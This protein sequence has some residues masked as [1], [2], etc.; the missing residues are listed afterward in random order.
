MKHPHYDV[1][2]AWAADISKAVQFRDADHQPWIDA[3]GIPSFRPAVQYRLK[4]E[5][6]PDVVKKYMCS[7]KDGHP[8][9]RN[10]EH[11]QEA[12][13]SLTFDG[14]TCALKGVELLR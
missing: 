13:L 14:E 2:V 3:Q 12:N 9:I 6:K 7:M 5:P 1:I 11:W 8:Y 10:A 4:P